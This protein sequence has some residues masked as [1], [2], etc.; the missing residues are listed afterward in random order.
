VAALLTL[1][2]AACG[3]AEE[4][5]ELTVAAAAS[6]TAA[7]TD[8]GAAF[9]D[10]HPEARVSFTFGPSD[11]LATQIVE[12]APVDVFA[13]ASPTWMDLVET[14]GP[15]VT[16]RTDFARNRLAIVV[17]VE[18]PAGIEGIHD[19][20]R[21]GVQLVLAAEGVPAGDYARQILA[22][23][24]IAGA[25]LANVV[26]NEEDVAQVMTKVLSGDA[27]AGIAYVTDV[28]TELADRIALIEIPDDV[29]VIATYPIAIVNGTEEG[30]LARAFV[31]FVLGPGRATL[32]GYGFPGPA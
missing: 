10:G 9:N 18:N 23:A 17:P 25:A 22:N 13:S 20:A 2:C 31:D 26:S 8:V 24:G 27:D 15:G 28:T 6:L 11:G 3:A 14:E 32:A 5:R 7:F 30:D 21:E 4:P 16:G 1:A 19:L 29:N 12:G